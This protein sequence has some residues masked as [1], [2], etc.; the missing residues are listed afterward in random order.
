M[1]LIWKSEQ[2]INNDDALNSRYAVHFASVGNIEIHRYYNWF[3]LQILILN[4]YHG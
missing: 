1:F 4:F 3:N 2:K